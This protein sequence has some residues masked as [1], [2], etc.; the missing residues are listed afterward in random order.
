[1]APKQRTSSRL[2]IILE[3]SNML[4][5]LFFLSKASCL[6]IILSFRIKRMLSIEEHRTR[7]S[8]FCV[9]TQGRSLHISPQGSTSHITTIL[10]LQVDISL[11][12]LMIF[13]SQNHSLLILLIPIRAI[14]QIMMQAII[15]HSLK[16][17]TTVPICLYSLL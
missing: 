8:S 16:G 4:H 15:S 6:S 2:Y 1:M 13:F 3:D 5:E 10:A 9:Q 17:S 11:Y 14:K 7:I 12:Q